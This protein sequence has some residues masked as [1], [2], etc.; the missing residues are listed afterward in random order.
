VGVELNKGAASFGHWPA[1]KRTTARV[2]VVSHEEYSVFFLVCPL[3][4]VSACSDQ[5]QRQ[6]V[7][8]AL[9]VSAEALESNDAARFF[10]VLDERSRFALSATVKE[11]LAAKELIARDY[12]EGDRAQALAALGDAGEVQTP[13][14][15]FARRCDAACL[16]GFRELVGAPAAERVEGDEVVVTTTRGTTLHMHAGTDR[17]YGLVWNTRALSDERARAARELKQ[18]RENAEIYRK[19]SALEGKE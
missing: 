9:A 2:K 15:L 6:S 13:A 1:S 3:L 8:G 19:R 16:R 14:E 10:N 7:R 18:I 17:T 5:A 4:A 11:R 12:P